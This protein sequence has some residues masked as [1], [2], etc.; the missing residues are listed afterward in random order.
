MNAVSPVLIGNVF[1][2]SPPFYVYEYKKN[3]LVFF[4][5]FYKY[6]LVFIKDRQSIKAWCAVLFYRF[7]QIKTK[8]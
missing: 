4:F 7:D 6:I 2:F 3:L 1:I 5:C 8:K